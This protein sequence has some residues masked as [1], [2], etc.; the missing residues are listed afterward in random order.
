MKLPS[1]FYW[2]TQTAY[3]AAVDGDVIRL[4]EY[5]FN[6]NLN[7]NRNISVTL[8]GGYD[9]SYTSNPQFGT[10]NGM[11]TISDGT[12]IVENLVIK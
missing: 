1:Q 7:L 4:Q 5:T 2:Q 3:N 11:L 9:C 10:I 8:K 6:E 12:V